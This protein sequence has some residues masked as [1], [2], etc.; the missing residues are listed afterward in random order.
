MAPHARCYDRLRRR[1]LDS[2]GENER[3]CVGEGVPPRLMTGCRGRWRRRESE[4]RD[5]DGMVRIRGGSSSSQVLTDERRR[6]RRGLGAAVATGHA[7]RRAHILVLAAGTGGIRRWM[8]PGAAQQ[9]GVLPQGQGQH[10]RNE[11]CSKHVD[12]RHVQRQDAIRASEER[13]RE[14]A[15][16]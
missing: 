4:L 8:A 9:R 12:A 11:G 7:W 6:P 2:E 16:S 10:E 5:T 13:P 1:D 3:S 15:G 14:I